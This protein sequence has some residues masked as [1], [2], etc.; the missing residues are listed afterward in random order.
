M[1][2]DAEFLAKHNLMDYS[3]L[4]VI[5]KIDLA[6]IQQNFIAPNKKYYESEL[7]TKVNEKNQSGKMHSYIQPS[8]KE[9]VNDNMKNSEFGGKKVSKENFLQRYHFGIID[10]LQDWNFTKKYENQFRKM[11]VQRS[12]INEQISAVPPDKYA[13]RFSTFLRN[14]VFMVCKASNESPFNQ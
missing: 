10:Y 11:Q 2:Q 7:L 12:A 3:L 8:F 4:L 1:E 6:N 5:E 14:N 13:S 9:H